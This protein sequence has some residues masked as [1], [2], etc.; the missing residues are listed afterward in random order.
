MY[1]KKALFLLFLSFFLYISTILEIIFLYLYFYL[2]NLIWDVSCRN[3]SIYCN[4]ND[5]SI[6][7]DARLPISQLRKNGNKTHLF[8]LALIY[9]CS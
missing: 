1:D 8:L 5:K 6:L 3:S 9:A 7:F 2:L 4:K